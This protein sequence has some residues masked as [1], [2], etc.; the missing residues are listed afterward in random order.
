M[1]LGAAG[2]VFGGKGFAFCAA[3]FGYPSRSP[4]LPLFFCYFS[5]R[6]VGFTT[7]AEG[8]LGGLTGNHQ[9]KKKDK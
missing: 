4:C 2:A 3:P 5:G 8:R 1:D 9:Q 6:L 7:L